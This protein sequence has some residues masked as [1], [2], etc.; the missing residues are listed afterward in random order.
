MS[1]TVVVPAGE[2]LFDSGEC[3][4]FPWPLVR[5]A[6]LD[7]GAESV[8]T[9]VLFGGLLELLQRHRGLEGCLASD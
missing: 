5:A 1:D 3:D 2:L 4:Q 8:K 9:M 7:L 6:V